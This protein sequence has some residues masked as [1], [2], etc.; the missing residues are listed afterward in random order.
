MLT[1]FDDFINLNNMGKYCK[2]F[3]CIKCRENNKNIDFVSDYDMI[4]NHTVYVTH[5]RF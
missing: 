5:E 1:D 2:D 3:K 4:V